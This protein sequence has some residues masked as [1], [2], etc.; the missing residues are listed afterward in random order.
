MADVCVQGSGTPRVGFCRNGG[1]TSRGRGAESDTVPYRPFSATCRHRAR[2]GSVPHLYGT[3][4]TS[5]GVKC[6]VVA[7]ALSLS[8]KG[9]RDT[10]AQYDFL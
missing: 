2:L 8:S 10:L 4:P 9:A 3:V 1:W 7:D 5:I 6:T